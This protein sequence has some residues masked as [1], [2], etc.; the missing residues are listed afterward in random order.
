MLDTD[1]GRSSPN[2]MSLK[3]AVQSTAHKLWLDGSRCDLIC[4]ISVVVIWGEGVGLQ[5][6]LSSEC[7]PGLS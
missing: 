6:L 3:K 5:V 7:P 1:S 4:S 2:L